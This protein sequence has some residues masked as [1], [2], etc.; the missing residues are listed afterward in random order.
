MRFCNRTKEIILSSYKSATT[1]EILD[2]IEDNSLRERSVE[3]IEKYVAKLVK[4]DERREFRRKKTEVWALS[5]P[6]RYRARTLVNGAKQRARKKG[7]PFDLTIDWVEDKLRDGYCEISNIK[8]YIKLYS[9]KE[10]YVRVHP[11]SPSLDQILPSGGYTMDN[12]QIVCDQVN[13]FKGDRHITSAIFVAKNLIKEYKRR[14]TPI[15]VVK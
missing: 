12:V 4:D 15:I 2:I 1:N 14:N 9:R 11:H 10:E 13:K 7:L 8:F 3:N 5:N 6:I